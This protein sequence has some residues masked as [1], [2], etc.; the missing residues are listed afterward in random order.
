[1][2]QEEKDT[3]KKGLLWGILGAVG[4]ALFALLIT[5]F[6]QDDQTI[7]IVF[8]VL[9]AFGGYAIVSQC[10]WGNSVLSVFTFFLRSF[11]LPCIIFALSL[12]GIIFLIFVKVLG[13][14][15]GAILSFLLFIIGLIVTSVYAIVIFPFA[16]IKEIRD[17]KKM[18]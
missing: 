2:Q 3:L 4:L 1:M 14:I 8:T 13:A 17:I 5:Y 9:G 18:Y 6:G 15:I 12:D 10:I 7:V 11:K 16:L